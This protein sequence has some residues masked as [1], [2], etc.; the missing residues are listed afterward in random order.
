MFQRLEV[1]VRRALG[2]VYW[3]RGQ[4]IMSDLLLL[5]NKVLSGK[6]FLASWQI[7]SW[8]GPDTGTRIESQ[9]LHSIYSVRSNMNKRKWWCQP[10]S[11]IFSVASKH[12][13]GLTNQVLLPWPSSR[14][15]DWDLQ[16]LLEVQDK[17]S[18]LEIT[19]NQQK[20][21]AIT[22]VKQPALLCKIQPWKHRP[23]A[24]QLGGSN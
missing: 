5:G 21:T 4:E 11:L 23:E 13:R 16:T 6:W 10:T 3:G 24:T 20:F 14:V 9:Y 15:V 7:S 18:S 1:C 19:D 17:T 22:V 2:C 8:E 12:H